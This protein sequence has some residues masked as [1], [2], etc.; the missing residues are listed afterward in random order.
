MYLIWS[1]WWDKKR[2]AAADVIADNFIEMTRKMIAQITRKM[3]RMQKKLFLRQ[4]QNLCYI[5]SNGWERSRS[6]WRQLKGRHTWRRNT[7]QS[8]S[9]SQT[10]IDTSVIQLAP[11]SSLTASLAQWRRL[12]PEPQRGITIC[13]IHLISSSHQRPPVLLY[14]PY[15]RGRRSFYTD[16]VTTD[17]G[18]SEFWEDRPHLLVRGRHRIV[19][20][21]RVDLIN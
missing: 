3:I 4:M 17:W 12:L 21:L 1:H 7:Y 20:M 15:L 19:K 13:R 18:D 9:L 2:Y 5:A 16:D 8:A 10:T 14:S 6:G 11:A